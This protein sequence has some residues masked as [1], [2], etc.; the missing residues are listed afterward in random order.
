MKITVYSAKKFWNPF[1]ISANKDA[2][3][4][5]Y[6]A[7]ALDSETANPKQLVISNFPYS[8]EMSLVHLL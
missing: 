4:V 7:D 3:K 2:H 5:S 1:L 8:Q 6:T